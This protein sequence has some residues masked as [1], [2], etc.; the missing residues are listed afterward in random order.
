MRSASNAEEAVRHVAAH[1]DRVRV[2]PFLDGGPCSIHGIVFPDHIAA[3]RPVEMVTLRRGRGTG[4]G[5]STFA[6]RELGPNVGRLIAGT[7]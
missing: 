1:C 3:S 4:A 7:P 6:D 5:S 2:M